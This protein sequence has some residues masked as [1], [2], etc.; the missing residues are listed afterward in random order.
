[1]NLFS[2]MKMTVKVPLAMMAMAILNLGSMWYALSDGAD[3][4]AL[5]V[6]L[7]QLV[8]DIVFA[9]FVS[10]S[11]SAPIATMTVSMQSLASGNIAGNIPFLDAANEVGDMARAVRTFKDNAIRM[12]AMEEQRQKQEKAN[13]QKV[14]T[15]EQNVVRFDSS[16]QGSI[17]T[18]DTC[19]QELKS[20]GDSVADASEHTNKK[21]FAVTE[22]IKQVSDNI[23]AVSSATEEMT[24]SI[25]EIDR[26]V[27]ESNR[28]TEDAVEEARRTDEIVS[29][30]AES[31]QRIGDVVGLISDIAEQ[32][33]LLALN[34]TIEAARAGDAGK[35]FAVVASEV[36]NLAGQTGKATDD[37]SK[38]VGEIQVVS[39]KAVRAIQTI[40]KTIGNINEI[41]STISAAVEEQSAAAQEISANVQQTASAAS[42]VNQN[43]NE[44]SDQAHKAGEEALKVMSANDDL[45]AGTAKLEQE[46]S[47][48]VKNIRG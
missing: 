4:T 23:Q 28:I 8:I 3:A 39:E 2:N 45:E 10:R 26:Q 14:E 46:I 48:F 34:A 47:Q 15:I 32:T 5:Y 25:G 35:G 24:A 18:L 41:S 16:I 21:V 17:K 36:K 38:H 42:D 37:I 19:L 29:G 44:V 7:G 31:A 13:K 30:L 11:L 27:G 9:V 1:M 6:L 20:V 12:E 40:G 22:A 43:I 33:N